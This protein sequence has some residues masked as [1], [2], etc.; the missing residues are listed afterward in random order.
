[1]KA[2]PRATIMPKR[3]LAMCC[4]LGACLFWLSVSAAEAATQAPAGQAGAQGMVVNTYGMEDPLRGMMVPQIVSRVLNWALPM[5]GSLLL[6]M[7]IWGGLQWFM[8]GGDKSKVEKATK[9]LTNAAIGMAIIIGAY[10]IVDNLV[11][12]IGGLT[13]APSTS[14]PAPQAQGPYQA[15]G[16]NTEGK[17]LP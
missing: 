17:N 9:T 16:P 15:P 10:V 13:E 1:M 2:Q 3:P 8:A 14:N 7:F 11:T 12:R 6:L 5:T 4:L